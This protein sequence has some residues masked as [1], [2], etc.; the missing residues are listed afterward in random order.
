MQYNNIIYIVYSFICN[1]RPISSIKLNKA[2]FECIGMSDS[3]YRA[4]GICTNLLSICYQSFHHL[5]TL[6][7]KLHIRTNSIYHYSKIM[8][9]GIWQDFGILLWHSFVHFA[10]GTFFGVD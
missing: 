8:C 4:F 10:S 5:V 1:I 6:I 7:Y 3:I 9:I 2:H